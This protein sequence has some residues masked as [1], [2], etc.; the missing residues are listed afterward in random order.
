[1][2]IIQLTRVPMHPMSPANR[3]H[4]GATPRVNLNA[5]QSDEKTPQKIRG[6]KPGERIISNRR[7]LDEKRAAAVYKSWKDYAVP[8]GRIRCRVEIIQRESASGKTPAGN[9]NALSTPVRRLRRQPAS[10]RSVRK[11]AG[12]HLRSRR[13]RL[14]T[15]QDRKVQKLP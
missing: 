12:T 14:C 13:L 1:M 5:L 9:L 8:R 6:G 7:Q 2:R 4:L 11:N 15:N 3:A 10:V